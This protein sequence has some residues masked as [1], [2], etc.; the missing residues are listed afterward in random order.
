MGSSH[1]HAMFAYATLRLKELIKVSGVELLLKLALTV[2]L[3][4]FVGY[5]AP[6]IGLIVVRIGGVQFAYRNLTRRA[7]AA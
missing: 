1:T 7:L 5:L 3:F 6:M 4:P 2:T